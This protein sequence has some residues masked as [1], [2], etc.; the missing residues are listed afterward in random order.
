MRRTLPGSA[1]CRVCELAM[2]V[3]VA[4]RRKPPAWSDGADGDLPIDQPRVRRCRHLDAGG[5]AV[6]ARVPLRGLSRPSC[7][8]MPERSGGRTASRRAET[9]RHRFEA[10]RHAWSR[11]RRD[12]ARSDRS[13]GW[14]FNLSARDEGLDASRVFSGESIRVAA[15]CSVRSAGG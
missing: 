9:C 5:R 14:L 10:P 7:G 3:T 6:G 8:D 2:I 1:A 11:R 13:G 15:S 12:R 4:S